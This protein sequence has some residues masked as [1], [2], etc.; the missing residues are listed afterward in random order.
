MFSVAFLNAMLNVVIL[1]VIMLNVVAPSD[2][3]KL[4]IALN[5]LI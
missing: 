4:S 2:T 5:Q 3:L 1:R